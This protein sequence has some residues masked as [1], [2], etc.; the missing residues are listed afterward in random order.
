[1]DP[2]KRLAFQ[3]LGQKSRR[4]STKVS[5]VSE[6]VRRCHNPWGSW[7]TP[8]APRPPGRLAPAGARGRRRLANRAS[9]SRAR[10][11]ADR[12]PEATAPRWGV[13]PRPGAASGCRPP[14]ERYQDTPLGTVALGG[15]GPYQ[16]W[17]AGIAPSKAWERRKDVNDDITETFHRN[18][19]GNQSHPVEPGRQPAARLAPRPARDATKRRQPVPKPC[20]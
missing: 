17:H 6:G 8:R 4:G 9:A 10:P 12:W 2:S 14:P 3:G 16:P 18:P 13:S 5:K 15:G 11:M 19:V 1:M 20:D 7:W